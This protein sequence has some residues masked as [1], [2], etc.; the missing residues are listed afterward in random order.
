[1]RSRWAVKAQRLRFRVVAAGLAPDR[2]VF[3]AKV[4]TADFPALCALADLFL[5]TAHYGAGATGVAALQAD[6]PL[7]TC[8]GETFASRMGA[9]LCAAVEQ[10]ELIGASP[11][12]TV[13]QAIEL[14]LAPGRLQSLR[15]RLL[16]DAERLPLFQT[17]AWVGHLEAL[18]ESLV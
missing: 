14:G 10:E 12:A 16:D 1:V 4:A 9:S 17:A 11:E 13:A 2:L 5:D 18:L 3:S 8:P 15:R 7:L 6:L